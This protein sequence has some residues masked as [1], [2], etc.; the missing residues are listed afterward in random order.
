MHVATFKAFRQVVGGEAGRGQLPFLVVSVETEQFVGAVS[1][2]ARDFCRSSRRATSRG[3]CG[4]SC[5]RCHCSSHNND[6]FR[7]HLERLRDSKKLVKDLHDARNRKLLQEVETFSICAD[8]QYLLWPCPSR[9]PLNIPRAWQALLLGAIGATLKRYIA[10]RV[11]VWQAKRFGVQKYEVKELNNACVAKAKDYL[12]GFLLLAR[13]MICPFS[14][15]L[16][17]IYH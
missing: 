17:L 8:L 10:S 16:L 12:D 3:T 15:S 14:S 4:L 7:K 6:L 9:S 2:A 5:H 11:T 13:D 1:M